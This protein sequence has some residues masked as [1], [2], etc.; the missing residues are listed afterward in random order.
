[1]MF[2]TRGIYGIFFVLLF[3]LKSSTI[4]AYTHDSNHA[5]KA[6]HCQTCEIQQL[7]SPLLLVA[8]IDCI[9]NNNFAIVTS[10]QC[11]QTPA[12]VLTYSA[13][14]NIWSRPPPSNYNS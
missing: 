8:E 9:V 12:Q 5:D 3:F 13:Y 6:S 2:T 14:T 10:K 11:K 4:H 7:Q 1:M